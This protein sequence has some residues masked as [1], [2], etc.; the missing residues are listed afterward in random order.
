MCLGS[1]SQERLLPK[2]EV[3]AD[4]Y[5]VW[6][7]ETPGAGGRGAHPIAPCIP[8]AAQ[9][10][11]LPGA[12][13]VSAPGYTKA[14]S[15]PASCSKVGQTGCSGLLQPA[16]ARNDCLAAAGLSS[17]VTTDGSA[18]G[19]KTRGWQPIENTG[20]GIS[21]VCIFGRTQFRLRRQPLASPKS[22]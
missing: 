6:R 12:A 15:D 10:S 5:K 21:A 19:H 20:R 13:G 2:V 9:R 11:T 1:R 4:Y 14:A 3:L 22:A 16:S 18:K 8:S 17:P 7:Q